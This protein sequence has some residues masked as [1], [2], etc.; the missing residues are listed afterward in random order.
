ME[1]SGREGHLYLHDLDCVAASGHLDILVW[2]HKNTN[3]GFSADAM[4]LA[5]AKGTYILFSDCTRSAMTAARLRP[6][7][8]P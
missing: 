6:W 5:A 4:A 8:R 2:L 1:I 7:T 3:V